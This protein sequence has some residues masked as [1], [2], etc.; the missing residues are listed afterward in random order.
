MLNR[1][2]T[3]ISKCFAVLCPRLSETFLFSV[4]IFDNNSSYW[5]Y[6]QLCLKKFYQKNTTSQSW[7]GSNA[8]FWSKPNRKKSKCSQEA[9]QFRTFGQC[10]HIIFAL[11]LWERLWSFKR[12]QNIEICRRVGRLK[13]LFNEISLTKLMK[14]WQKIKQNWTGQETLISD[15]VKFLTTSTNFFFWKRDWVLSSVFSHFW[16]FSN[17]F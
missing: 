8:A 17:I 13:K 14:W 15:F 6:L 10:T 16:D 4:N 12:D 9:T 11:K 7:K 5:N 3:K 1:T 2:Y